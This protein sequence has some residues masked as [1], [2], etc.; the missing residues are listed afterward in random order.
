MV[1]QWR[2]WLAQ[3]IGALGLEVTPSAANYVLVRFPTE[4]GRAA[5]DAEAFLASRGYLVRG[6]A[7]YG[8]PEHLRITIGLEEHNRAVVDLLAE[9]LA[10]ARGA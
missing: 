3:Q 1:E 9:F 4:P 5:A 10:S 2:L 8:L 7:G 6:V